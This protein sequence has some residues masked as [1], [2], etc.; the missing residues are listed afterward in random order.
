MKNYLL[1]IITVLVLQFAI[2]F[3]WHYGIDNEYE[4]MTSNSFKALEVLKGTPLVD[5]VTERC[6]NRMGKRMRVREWFQCNSVQ[7]FF[8]DLMFG[9]Q[10]NEE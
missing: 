1:G 7:I 8:S 10:S 6:T 4:N 9:E 5:V 3:S 2:N